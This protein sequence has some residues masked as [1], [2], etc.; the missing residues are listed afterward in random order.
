MFERHTRDPRPPRRPRWAATLALALFASMLV[1]DASPAARAKATELRSAALLDLRDV[2]ADRLLAPRTPPRPEPQP[3]EEFTS[4]IDGA[5][6]PPL[7][8]RWELANEKRAPV[9]VLLAT[10]QNPHRHPVVADLVLQGIGLDQRVA[11]RK[12]RRVRLKGGQA[13]QVRVPVRRLPVQSIGAPSAFEIHATIKGHEGGPVVVPSEQIYAQHLPGYKTAIVSTPEDARA[14]FARNDFRGSRAFAK[15]WKRIVAPLL[16]PR[17]RVYDAKSRGFVDIGSLP[18][19]GRARALGQAS[20]AMTDKEAALVKDILQKQQPDLPSPW[21]PEPKEGTRLCAS[22]HA[23]FVDAGYGEDYLAQKGLQTVP[24]RYARAILTTDANQLVWQGVLDGQGC[25]E[26]LS[27]ED[28]SFIF[29]LIPEMYKDGAAIDV[30]F[31]KENGVEFGEWFLT[32]FSLFT[33]PNSPP[34][35]SDINIVSGHDDI[36]RVSAVMSQI[37][38]TP[39]NGMPAEAIDIWADSKCGGDPNSYSA[40]AGL[41]VMYIGERK[42]GGHNSFWKYVIAHEFGHVQQRLEMGIPHKDYDAFAPPEPGCRCDHV[43][44]SNKKHCMQSLEEAGVAQV[45]GWAQ[46]YAAKAFNDPA[47]NDCTHVYYKEYLYLDKEFPSAHTPPVPRDCRGMVRWHYNYCWHPGQDVSTE[48]DWMN[49]LWSANTVSSSR[50]TMDDLA[51]IFRTACT[52]GG[53]LCGTWDH[54]TWPD[55]VA[56]SEVHHGGAST[57]EHLHFLQSGDDHKV[58]D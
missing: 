3:D 33:I 43:V 16:K 44:S 48:H 6:A 2:S 27:L 11:S 49:F 20:L 12:L 36:T 39:D 25:S 1:P 55:F 7:I 56:A 10:I 22:W 34:G 5:G 4:C 50:S 18:S 8:T 14:R 19:D 51:A 30:F 53:G 52:G 13:K 32:A 28:Q 42:Q 29:I 21:P 15:G 24:A 57:P 17:G 38:A 23:S 47:Q 35:V 9:K 37:L 58:N 40:C 26:I 54:L 41:K 31:K 45:E 46:F